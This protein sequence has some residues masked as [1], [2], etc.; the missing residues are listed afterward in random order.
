MHGFV[1]PLNY[2][3]LINASEGSAFLCG[4][5][6]VLLISPE[7]LDVPFP[8]VTQ[9]LPIRQ[10]L[11]TCFLAPAPFTGSQYGEDHLGAHK[12]SGCSQGSVRFK[13]DQNDSLKNIKG[14]KF[15]FLKAGLITG[16]E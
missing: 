4:F 12:D 16:R 2:S 9:P 15:I 8:T 3:Q 13:D 10:D 5:R 7:W 1:F 6:V 11:P 14:R